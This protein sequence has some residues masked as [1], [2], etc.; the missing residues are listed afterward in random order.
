MKKWGLLLPIVLILLFGCMGAEIKRGVHKNYFYSYYP[1]LAIE[2]PDSFDF[3]ERK[4]E[5]EWGSYYHSEAGSQMGVNKFIF[6]DLMN[7]AAVII[8]IVKIAKGYWMPVSNEG[9]KN[10][11][12]EGHDTLNNKRYLYGVWVQK[13][14]HDA[15]LMIKR[16]G[17]NFGGNSDIRFDAYYIEHVN[18]DLF[19]CDHPI[20]IESLTTK[21]SDFLSQFMRNSSERMKHINLSEIKSDIDTP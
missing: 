8:N 21:Q 2:M 18:K 13:D 20:K 19:N 14:E 5:T 4:S 3:V 11:L 1:E 6:V 16:H 17:H 7:R 12:L 10:L 15:C 9:I